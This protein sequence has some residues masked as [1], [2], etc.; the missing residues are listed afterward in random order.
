VEGGK[1]ANARSKENK[2]YYIVA[3]IAETDNYKAGTAFTGFMIAAKTISPNQ[4]GVVILEDGPFYYT[5]EAVEPKVLKVMDGDKEIPASDYTVT[6]DCNVDATPWAYVIFNNSGYSNSGNYYF[7][8]SKIF[9][10]KK[11]TM[12]D[13]PPIPKTD[14]VYTG[15]SLELVTAGE[16]PDGTKCWYSTSPN[17]NA[18]SGSATATEAGTHK[19]WYMFDGG[20]NYDNNLGRYDEKR[21]VE[22]TI[23]KQP[24]EESDVSVEISGTYTYMSGYP[25]K[26]YFNVKVKGNN[27][28]EGSGY[29]VTYENNTQAG[30]GKAII[31]GKN[32]DFK[33]VKEFEIQKRAYTPAVSADNWVSGKENTA[34]VSNV[35]KEV[36]DENPQITYEYKPKDADDNEYSTVVPTQ[37]GE[38]TVRVTIPESS[39]YKTATVTKDFKIV[40]PEG[41]V[42]VSGN[43]PP[44]KEGSLF[45]GYFTDKTCT[46]SYTGTDGVA[47]A[48]FVDADKYLKVDKPVFSSNGSKGTLQFSTIV[49]D[50]SFKEVRFEIKIGNSTKKVKVDKLFMADDGCK[51]VY[52]LNNITK[53]YFGKEVTITPSWTT[54]DGTIITGTSTNYT[55]PKQ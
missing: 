9:E 23:A 44:T 37:D 15:S 11:A 45:A 54:L 31:E 3:E 53:K 7:N 8:S 22:V 46:K 33:I 34:S 39:N 40:L 36:L 10:I 41:F 49:P 20:T 35:P 30:T 24:V 27:I 12:P 16:I 50:S 28:Y 47:Y 5:G 52:T 26:P 43:I 1:P 19:V 29:T 21:Y 2:P 38:Y 42:H 18:W 6:Y 51:A 48:K 55:I 14:L 4:E 25:V 13:I 32:Y 17:P